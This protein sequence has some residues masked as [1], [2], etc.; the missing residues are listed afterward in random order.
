MAGIMHTQSLNLFVSDS[1]GSVSAKYLAPEK[2]R[3]IMTLA[4]GAGAGMD[5]SFMEILAS[6]LAEESIATLRFNF[7]FSERGK[8]RPDRPVIAHETVAA[9]IAKAD[10]KSTR[11]NS[12]H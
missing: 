6:L 1:I 11:L 9:A 12:S 10:R 8:G 7:P 2:P 3:C 5:H 4:H